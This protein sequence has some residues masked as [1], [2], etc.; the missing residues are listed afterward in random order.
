MGGWFTAEVNK[1][2]MSALHVDSNNL[3]PSMIVG[4]GNYQEG[5]LFTLK[6]GELDWCVCTESIE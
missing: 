3:G 1:N 6:D 4:L 5:G 2:Y